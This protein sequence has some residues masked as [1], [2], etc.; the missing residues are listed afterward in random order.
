MSTRVDPR[1]FT[2]P[3]GHYPLGPPTASTDQFFDMAADLLCIAGVDGYFK[4][5][6]QAWSE[7]LGYEDGELLQRPF[8]DFVHPDDRRATIERVVPGRQ[9]LQ[10]RALPQ[11]LSMQGRHLQVAVRGRRRRR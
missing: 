5:V 3:P 2:T 10:A 9:R 1:W 6:N 4:V 11:P 8:V 7:A